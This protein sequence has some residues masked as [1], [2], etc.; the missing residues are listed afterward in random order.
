MTLGEIQMAKEIF[1]DTIRYPKVWIHKGSYLPFGLQSMGT[2]MSPNGEMYFRKEYSTDFSQANTRKKHV[3]IHELSH[4]WQYQHGMKVKLRGLVS[5]VAKYEYALDSWPL[6]TYGMEQQAQIIADYYILTQ[7][8]SRG[9]WD[10]SNK[11]TNCDDLSD[12]ELLKQYKYTLRALP[13]SL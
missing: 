11:C 9:D 6:S 4:V 7:P 8:N 3:F 5:W 10:W 1:R 2:S 12:D 13:W